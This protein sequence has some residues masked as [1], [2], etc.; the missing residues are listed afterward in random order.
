MPNPVQEDIQNLQRAN[1]EL[2][3]RLLD[4][5]NEMRLLRKS[6][7]VD[8]KREECGNSQSGETDDAI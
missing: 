8:E 3:N 4:L 6:R 2:I 7:G 1:A 5:E